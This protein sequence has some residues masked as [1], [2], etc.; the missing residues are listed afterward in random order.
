LSEKKNPLTEYAEY[1]SLGAEI[2]IGLAAPIL[3]GYWLDEFFETSPWILL[4]GC[5]IGIVNIF[6]IIFQLAKRLDK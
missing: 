4:A 6:F 3:I 5:A 2:A 1:L